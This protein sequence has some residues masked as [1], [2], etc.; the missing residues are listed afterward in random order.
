MAASLWPQWTV[1]RQA[2]L[3][4]V[5]WSLPKFMS[6]E[7]VMPSNHL[8]L[9]CSLLLLKYIAEVYFVNIF[10]IIFIINGLVY[11]LYQKN[12]IKMYLLWPLSQFC[13][14]KVLLTQCTSPKHPVSCIDP[15]LVIHFIYDIIHVLMPFS[16]VIPPSVY[17]WQIHVDVWQNQYNIVK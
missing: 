3:S 2:S 13:V 14:F 9:C 6:F 11:N 8:I 7:S 15:G 10:A 17:L 4:T 5:F 12:N 1:A 16:Q